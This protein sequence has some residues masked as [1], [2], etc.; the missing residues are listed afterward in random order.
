MT[1]TLSKPSEEK[2]AITPAT[3]N[4]QGPWKIAWCHTGD[5]GGSKRAAFEMVREL[6]R[7]G[8]VIDEYIIRIGEPNL[9]HWP[10]R[11][12]VRES[13]QYLLPRQACYAL[14]PYLV[15]TW[16]DLAQNLLKRRSLR[17]TNVDVCQKMRR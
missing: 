15:K 1:A 12:F 5:S 7:R 4:G 10:L 14:R 13:Y 17:S 8:H 3:T 2:K 6:A 9:S 11:P 16:F